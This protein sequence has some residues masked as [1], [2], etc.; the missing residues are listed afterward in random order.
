MLFSLVGYF[1]FA[2]VHTMA[3]YYA[4]A[5]IIGLGN[6]HMYPA[7]QNIFINLALPSQ[8]GIANAS[9]LTSWD[10]GIG[11]GVLLGGA[12]AE[13]LGYHAAFWT[14]AIGNMIGVVFFLIYA[15]KTYIASTDIK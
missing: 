10:A 1:V 3:G 14:A 11:L 5:I 4:S 15:R 12:I 2:A 8:R 13:T 6:G 9:I 7:M